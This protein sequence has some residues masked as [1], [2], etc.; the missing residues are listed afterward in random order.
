MQ[1]KWIGFALALMGTL[2]T[3]QSFGLSKYDVRMSYFNYSFISQTRDFEIP[4]TN[5]HFLSLD[6]QTSDFQ[7]FAPSQ[8]Q[9]N[10]ARGNGFQSRVSGF[11]ALESPAF[12]NLN[13][14]D[15][16]Y[17]DEILAIGRKVYRWSQLDSIWQ[18]GI[19]EPQYRSRS[20]LP[21]EQG[22]TGLFLNIPITA[23]KLP[24]GLH[25]FASPMFFPD[26]GPGYL[27]EDGRFIAQNPW[28]TLPPTEAYISNTGV[29][30]SLKYSIVIPSI[31][32][33]VLNSS[34]GGMLTFGESENLGW[35]SQLG[36]FVKPNSRLNVAANAYVQ[37][38][39]SI[40]VEIHP[41][42]ELQ[43]LL[44]ADFQYRFS[45]LLTINTGLIFE[46]NEAVAQDSS[47]TR[48]SM[49]QR[50]L[51]HATVTLPLRLASS[52]LRFG[53]LAPI[54]SDQVK[55]TGEKLEELRQILTSQR[56]Q[57]RPQYQLEYQHG[58][59]RVQYR[60]SPEENFE[61][62]AASFE[63]PVDEHWLITAQAE[64]FKAPAQSGY[65]TRYANLDWAH[66]GVTY[67]F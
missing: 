9:D 20:F 51:A 31:N 13:V 16:Y 27:L 66:L 32:R 2:L 57:S 1:L 28:F 37:A 15:F 41:E 30:D 42:V 39:D 11:Y 26:Q 10:E 23:W 65:Y 5:I 45:N 54:G 34:F 29:T 61:L 58:W 62:I 12:S 6:F 67:A 44:F 18:M 4:R 49:T 21:V 53:V 59:G 60:T 63:V 25:I 64:L 48:V 35:Y 47:L 36:S 19:L 50:S 52:A 7:V 55:V 24:I 40:L 14:Q 46:N 56:W 8:N 17:Q 3:F 38:N 22:L 33:I 43:K